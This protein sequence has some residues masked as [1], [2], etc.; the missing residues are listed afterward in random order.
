MVKSIINNW[1]IYSGLNAKRI[2]IYVLFAGIAIFLFS[3]FEMKVLNNSEMVTNTLSVSIIASI[4]YVF[5]LGVWGNVQLNNKTNTYYLTM[6][7]RVQI[8]KDYYKVMYCQYLLICIAAVTG[9]YLGAF[10]AKSPM[11]NG[12]IKLIIDWEFA[13]L[14]FA[15]MTFILG[16]KKGFLFALLPVSAIFIAAFSLVKKYFFKPGIVIVLVFG[17]LAV[18]STYISYKRWFRIIEKRYSDL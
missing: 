12:F 13:V 14:I 8:F 11:E 10:I 2:W 9:N 15:V 6:K 3:I 16:L 5:S 7:N 1:K 18:V 4:A 17:V